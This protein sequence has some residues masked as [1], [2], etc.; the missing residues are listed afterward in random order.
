VS[1]TTPSLA[2][3]RRV[4]LPPN[5]PHGWLDVRHR[6]LGPAERLTRNSQRRIES[7]FRRQRG[8]NELDRSSVPTPSWA[9]RIR[10]APSTS[11]TAVPCA[12]GTTVPPCSSRRGSRRAARLAAV[13]PRRIRRSSS[14]GGAIS[15]RSCAT[16][17]G[18]TRRDAMGD[19]QGE[20]AGNGRGAAKLLGGAGEQLSPTALNIG[21]PRA[22]LLCGR[23]KHW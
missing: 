2:P 23:K 8:E 11:M 17:T 18:A 9:S 4:S 10:S 6:R 20:R 5:L 21:C 1:A 22:V 12:R 15:N 7:I 14:A 3:A 19:P 16:V 13:P